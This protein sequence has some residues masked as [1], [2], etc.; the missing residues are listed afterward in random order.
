[1]K[2][3]SI[4]LLAVC[5][6]VGSAQDLSKQVSFRHV[7]APL[8]ILL[9]DFSAQ[10]GLP[11]AAGDDVKHEVLI[12]N[13]KNV[14][15]KELLEQMCFTIDAGIKM[16]RGKV[17]ITRTPQQEQAREKRNAAARVEDFRKI[18]D[19]QKELAAKY[20][21]LDEKGAAGMAARHLALKSKYP[22]PYSNDYAAFNKEY[23]G[24]SDQL[25]LNKAIALIVSA[26]DPAT[27]AAVPDD[28][29]VV[30][31]S[32]P[33]K[34]QLQLPNIDDALKKIV[35][36]QKAFGAAVAKGEGTGKTEAP[37]W[38]LDDAAKPFTSAPSK[39][40]LTITRPSFGNSPTVAIIFA[41]EKGRFIQNTGGSLGS[42]EERAFNNLLKPAKDKEAKPLTLS[43]ISKKFV[44]YMKGG[45]RSN[46]NMSAVQDPE[47]RTFLLNPE[48]HDPLE[49]V[50]SDAV[51][52]AAEE[53]G[54]PTILQ[55]QDML[56]LIGGVSA[57]AE[58][59]AMT[60]LE[61]MMPLSDLEKVDNKGWQVFRNRHP[62][63]TAAQNVDREALGVLV[64]TEIAK[65]RMA[66]EDFAAFQSKTEIPFPRT[67]APYYFLLL[68]PDEFFASNLAQ[69]ESAGF[70]Q[71][72][73]MLSSEQRATAMKEGGITYKN[74][75]ERQQKI[76]EKMVYGNAPRF[77]YMNMPGKGQVYGTLM[78]EPTEAF[79]NG[80][81]E[82]AIFRYGINSAPAVFGKGTIPGG[83]GSR[84]TLEAIHASEIATAMI[85]KETPGAPQ[86]A[87]REFSDFVQGTSTEWSFMLEVSKIASIHE[88]LKDN[89]WDKEAKPLR[90]EQLPDSFHK[91]VAEALA[92]YR[93]MAKQGFPLF[94]GS[95]AKPVKPPLV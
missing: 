43:S 11:V 54:R 80:V 81:P 48:K 70:L 71:L 18:I 36:D 35:D 63:D 79:P 21:P 76:V 47:L 44:D 23:K 2:T 40:L 86:F 67:F 30:F 94:G 25:P 95:G 41:D 5:A 10:T 32:K 52:Q 26:L 59:P 90:Y 22:D 3:L 89:Q 9:S 82:D 37:P 93:Q 33:N 50:V 58:V 51:L 66:I 53:S 55:G 62:V 7:A 8:S 4:L 34:L 83:Q 87:A 72:F 1:M 75:S 20:Q 24:L 92:R 38:P 46:G 68:M 19:K 65:K 56:L 13:A 84:S 77:E 49:L 57:T 12:I 88:S 73:G 64:R 85:A 69:V 6:A 15:A 27:I 60:L 31:S 45:M 14:S 17:F 28:Y 16:E 91:E 39:I 61:R 74:L 78:T 29:K 42:D